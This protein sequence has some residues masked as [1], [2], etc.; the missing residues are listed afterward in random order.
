MGAATFVG[1]DAYIG[2]VVLNSGPIL[3]MW[4]DLF[5]EGDSV[6]WHTEVTGE[7]PSFSTQFML[8]NEQFLPFVKKCII[9][10]G[11]G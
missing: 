5:S 7:H 11:F 1:T 10:R 3:I 6:I 2:Q 4:L 8:L 9:L